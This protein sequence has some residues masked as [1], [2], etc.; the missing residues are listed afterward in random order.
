MGG[1]NG[2][3]LV[4]TLIALQLDLNILDEFHKVILHVSGGLRSRSCAKVHLEPGAP[5]VLHW[6]PKEGL[7][8][9][10]I[11]A[12]KGLDLQLGN[13]LREHISSSLYGNILCW[14]GMS[15]LLR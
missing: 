5:L 4:G 1:F 10:F 11:S 13:P 7:F 14:A 15:E 3:T 9:R 2:A 6:Y 12:Q 8:W